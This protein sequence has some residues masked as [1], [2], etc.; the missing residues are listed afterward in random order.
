MVA[1]IYGSTFVQLLYIYI[2]VYKIGSN[3]DGACYIIDI[4]H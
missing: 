1:V 2:V 4:I 3:D